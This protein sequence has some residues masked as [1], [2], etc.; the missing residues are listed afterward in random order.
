MKKFIMGAVALLGACTVGLFVTLQPGE[1][2][3]SLLTQNVE[4]LAQGEIDPNC[5]NGCLWSSGAGCYC[6]TYYP[7]VE[8]YVW[9]N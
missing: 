4:A 5:P 2:T 9:P 3:S 8:E 1:T 6:F 7:Y